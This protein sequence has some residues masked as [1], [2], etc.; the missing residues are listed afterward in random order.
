[1]LIVKVTEFVMVINK[2]FCFFFFLLLLSVFSFAFAFLFS[3]V[4]HCAIRAM[5]YTH[6][7]RILISADDAGIVQYSDSTLKPIS[8]FPAHENP[9]RDI[10]LG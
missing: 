3:Q 8:N 2:F 10:W 5:E 1:M 7:D 6:D 9:I 4:H